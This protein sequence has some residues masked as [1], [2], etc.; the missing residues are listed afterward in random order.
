MSKSPSSTRRWGCCAKP[1]S[2]MPPGIR[3][4]RGR[5]RQWSA[6]TARLSSGASSGSRRLRRGP[7]RTQRRWWTRRCISSPR[8]K[9]GLRRRTPTKASS[10]RWS[11]TT[12]RPT[13]CGSGASLWATCKRAMSGARARNRVLMGRRGRRRTRR[14][15]RR[16]SSH[17]RSRRRAESRLPTSSHARRRRRR[18]RSPRC[19]Q[20]SGTQ[21][22]TRPLWTK[23]EPQSCRL[24][25]RS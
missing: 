10:P 4:T 18:P 11:A 17:A 6:T 23:V 2:G 13:S 9:I 24:R 19:R 22:R 8:A 14:T 16:P 20:R 21:P 7:R 3:R 25:S 5:R 1:R 15:R 12:A